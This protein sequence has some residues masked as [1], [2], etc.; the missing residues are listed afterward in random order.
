M[1]ASL[2]ALLGWPEP[3]P[4]TIVDTYCCDRTYRYGDGP[5]WL[6]RVCINGYCIEWTCPGCG[7]HDGGYGPVECRCKQGGPNPLRI[8]GHAY[9][10]RTRNR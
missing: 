1:P 6:E 3:D 2:F 7:H 9:R 8:D 5:G 10:R 4:N